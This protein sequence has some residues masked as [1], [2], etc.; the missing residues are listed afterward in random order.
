MSFLELVTALA[1]ADYLFGGRPSSMPQWLGSS[2]RLVRALARV[3]KRRSDLLCRPPR[4]SR[5]RVAVGQHL[6][7][8]RLA[9]RGVETCKQFLHFVFQLHEL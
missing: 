8:E 9:A 7:F 6:A 4:P 1:S 5:A 3:K 2:Q